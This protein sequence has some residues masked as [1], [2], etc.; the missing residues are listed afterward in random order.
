MTPTEILDFW[1]HPPMSEHW[2]S[3]TPEIDQTIRTRYEALWEQA[4]Q[5]RLG[6]WQQT[7]EG[8]LALCIVLDQFPLNMFRGE[9]RSFS[10]EQLAVA[11]TRAAVARGLDRQLPKE[12]VAFL[13]LPLMHS[14]HMAD[15][16][17][18]V[19]L[20]ETSGLE[21]NIRFARHHRNIVA[22][23]GRFPHRNAILGR[24]S[25]AAEISYLNSDQAFK[26]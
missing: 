8:C 19:R 25:T 13:Y 7:A 17:E 1:Y 4:R 3:S 20:F 18:S 15:Q 10:T 12:Q 16:D 23:Y 11:V 14:E 9:P 24:T 5:G 21:H 22:T 26:G 2:F 6:H